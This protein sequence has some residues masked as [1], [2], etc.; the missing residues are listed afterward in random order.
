VRGV[1]EVLGRGYSDDPDL[2]VKQLDKHSWLVKLDL[3]ADE[4]YAAE[5]VKARGRAPCAWC[6]STSTPSTTSGAWPWTATKAHRR[7]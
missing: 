4:Y 3:N 5:P 6:A 2:R 7:S 1:Y